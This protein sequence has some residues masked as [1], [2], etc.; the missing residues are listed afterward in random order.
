MKM[1]KGELVLATGEIYQGFVPDKQ[2]GSF[3]GEIVFNTGMTGYVET[4]TDPSYAG[5]IIVFTYPLIGNYG[6]PTSETWESSKI[7]ARGVVMTEMARHFSHH[8]AKLSLAEFL[9]QQNVPWIEG[10][11]TRALTKH[12]RQF[13]VVSGAILSDDKIPPKF[14]DYATCHFVDEVT[15]KTMQTF[16]SG[17]KKLIVID[18]GMK[19]N[20]MRNLL[21]FPW[22]ILRV[23]YHYDFTHE[24]YDAVFISNGPGDPQMCLPTIEIIKKVFQQK[25]PTFGICLGTQLMALAAGATTYKLK[26]G[27]RSQNQPCIH[28]PT[29][30]AY[31]TSQNHSYAVDEKTLTNDWDILFRNLNDDSVEGII[32]K[33]LPF[34]AV[35]FH[36]ESSPGP[37]DTTWLFKEFYASV[38]NL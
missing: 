38:M 37:C 7:H 9:K 24:A 3:F 12:L 21:Q 31:L 27:H 10:I 36:P 17:N 26:F 6:V 19:E 2:Q 28:V 20:I 5:Q 8:A 13:G 35:Q 25:K 30:R 34:F 23:P 4:L 11:D 1:Q 32:H 22:E 16:G 33:S 14:P 15:T 29:Q 18:C